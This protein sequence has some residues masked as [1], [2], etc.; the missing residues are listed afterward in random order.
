MYGA[1]LVVTPNIQRLLS[2]G[3]LFTKAYAQYPLCSPSRTSF[4]TGWRPDH[5]RV[6]DDYVDPNTVLSLT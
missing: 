2:H 4:L 6:F 3:M 5:T 1:V